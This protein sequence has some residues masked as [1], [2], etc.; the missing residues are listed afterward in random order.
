[1][2]VFGDSGFSQTQRF[3]YSTISKLDFVLVKKQNVEVEIK[4]E[5]QFYESNEGSLLGW[6]QNQ[7]TETE[8]YIQQ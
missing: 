6:L 7:G 5:H 8:T 1:M 3:E 2:S 4:C